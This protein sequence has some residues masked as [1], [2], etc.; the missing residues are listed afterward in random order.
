[1]LGSLPSTGNSNTNLFAPFTRPDGFFGGAGARLLTLPLFQGCITLPD[2][3]PGVGQD[4]LITQYSHTDF[5]TSE[6]EDKDKD[7]GQGRMEDEEPHQGGRVHRRANN[8]GEAAY[9]TPLQGPV[10]LGED[11]FSTLTRRTKNPQ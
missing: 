1:M 2:E 8:T 7:K 9:D 10:V 4:S 5:S 11:H 3:Q 6:D